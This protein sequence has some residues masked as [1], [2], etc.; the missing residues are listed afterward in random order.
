MAATV[1]GLVLMLA[2][3]GPL[4]AVNQARLARDAQLAEQNQ[5]GLTK[6]ARDAEQ[7]T[8]RQMYATHVLAAQSL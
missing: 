7:E 1:V 2:V 3:F 5:A 4:V 6:K 8:R